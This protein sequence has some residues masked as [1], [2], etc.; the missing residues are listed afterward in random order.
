MHGGVCKVI[1]Q[2]QM[3]K[4]AKLKKTWTSIERGGHSTS[5]LASNAPGHSRDGPRWR[6][7]WPYTLPYVCIQWYNICNIWCTQ[8]NHAH[9]W[10]R[11]PR[12]TIP[13]HC[14]TCWSIRNTHLVNITSYWIC[15]RW[16]HVGIHTPYIRLGYSNV[17]LLLLPWRSLIWKGTKPCKAISARTVAPDKKAGMFPNQSFLVMCYYFM[18]MV[19]GGARRGVQVVVHG[20]L[21]YNV[22]HESGYT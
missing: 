14:N 19:W 7:P 1:A 16:T 10:S 2:F 6:R 13:Q 11:P 17:S 5:G 9:T 3:N 18:C 8:S 4:L 12:I 21:F 15:A 20:E 22:N